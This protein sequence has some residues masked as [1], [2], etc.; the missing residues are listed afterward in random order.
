MPILLRRRRTK[1][2]SRGQAEA[3]P[4]VISDDPT[5]ETGCV[6]FNP[7]ADTDPTPIFLRLS[8]SQDLW[9]DTTSCEVRFLR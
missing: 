6:S 8:N 7:N 4:P 1:D 9:L 5:R 2:V 3:R